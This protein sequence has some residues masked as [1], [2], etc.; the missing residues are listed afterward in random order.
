MRRIARAKTRTL[1]GNTSH[2]IGPT[3]VGLFID[4][5][6]Y[7]YVR[8]DSECVPVGPEPIPAGVCRNPHQTYKG[9]SGYRIVPGNTCDRN[10]G[11]KKDEQVMKKCSQGWSCLLWLSL[12][13]ATLRRDFSQRNSQRETLSIKRCAV[14]TCHR[15]AGNADMATAVSQSPFT[16]VTS[17]DSY[18]YQD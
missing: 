6:D 18:I 16:K 8:H 14:S 17:V 11:V 3:R 2:H 13:R 1:S 12:V 4:G 5:S 10:K 7:N 15:E 9:S